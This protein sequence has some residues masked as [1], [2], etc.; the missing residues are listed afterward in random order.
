LKPPAAFNAGEV[1]GSRL[2][3]YGLFHEIAQLCIT[4]KVFFDIGKKSNEF[5]DFLFGY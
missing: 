2:I 5:K 4:V 1:F 3:A